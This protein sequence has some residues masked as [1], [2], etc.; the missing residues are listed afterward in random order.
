MQ[1]VRKWLRMLCHR[2]PVRILADLKS[3]DNSDPNNAS[4][5]KDLFEE[6]DWWFRKERESLVRLMNLPYRP[7]VKL[8]DKDRVEIAD[9]IITLK[10]GALV[11]VSAVLDTDNCE[12]Y[13]RRSVD[14]L[15]YHADYFRLLGYE[16]CDLPMAFQWG[17][18]EVAKEVIL[19]YKA[20]GMSYDEICDKVVE[21]FD[22]LAQLV[23]RSVLAKYDLKKLSEHSFWQYIHVSIKSVSKSLFEQGHYAESVEA[24]L[25]EINVIIKKEFLKRTNHNA[26]GVD[27]MRKAFSAKNPVIRLS[28]SENEETR[29]SEQQGYMDLFAGAMAALRNPKAHANITMTKGDAVRQLMFAGLLLHRFESFVSQSAQVGEKVVPL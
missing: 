3:L 26:D 1:V 21:G 4:K 19:G 25:K 6:Y 27:L 9:D 5:R 18:A 10:L 15:S 13:I 2:P 22:E 16:E 17:S 8:S 11:A 12:D 29:L 23:K 14:A 24:A 28:N 7:K 20:S